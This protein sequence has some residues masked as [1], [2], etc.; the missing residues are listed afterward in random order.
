MEQFTLSAIW[1]GMLFG[2]FVVVKCIVLPGLPSR[3]VQDTTPQQ[4]VLPGDTPRGLGAGMPDCLLGTTA[5]LTHLVKRRN[6]MRPISTA[7]VHLSAQ[8]VLRERGL[9]GH[10]ADFM[11]TVSLHG[12]MDVWESLRQNLDLPETQEA[13]FACYR[14]LSG[15]GMLFLSGPETGHAMTFAHGLISDPS[16]P[17]GVSSWETL[18]EALKRYPAMWPKTVHVA[19]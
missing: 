14:H 12:Q 10:W 4:V 6:R 11:K 2:A 1:I 19:G 17:D 9:P 5:I 15:V 13:P 16:R 18:A 7:A 8:K 3:Q